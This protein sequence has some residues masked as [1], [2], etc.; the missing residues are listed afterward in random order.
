MVAR[1]GRAAGVSGKGEVAVQPGLAK[2]GWTGE[3]LLKQSS[4]DAAARE[5]VALAL[6]ARAGGGRF[7]SHFPT[8]PTLARAPCPDSIVAASRRDSR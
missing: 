3:A 6:L 2:P 8:V 7:A 5:A 1:I 4:G